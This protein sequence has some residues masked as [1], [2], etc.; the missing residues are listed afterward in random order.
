MKLKIGL[1]G[2]IGSGKSTAA[3]IFQ[4][5]GIEVIDADAISHDL[6]KTGTKTLEKIVAHFGEEIV[7]IQTGDVTINPSARLLIMTTEIFRN[8]ILEGSTRL[9]ERT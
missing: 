6:V 5:L 7:G 8:L 3:K 4:E 1:T 2:G 9:N